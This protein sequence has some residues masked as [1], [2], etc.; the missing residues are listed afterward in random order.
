MW[1]GTHWVYCSSAWFM[2]PLVVPVG[3]L[4]PVRA[5]CFRSCAEIVG[6]VGNLV[7]FCGGFGDLFLLQF[8]LLQIFFRRER[9]HF[10]GD[11]GGNLCLLVLN[12]VSLG[13]VDAGSLLEVQDLTVQILEERDLLFEVPDAV[14][15]ALAIFG[16]LL[17]NFGDRVLGVGRDGRFSSP[18]LEVFVRGCAGHRRRGFR[19]DWQ[20]HLASFGPLGMPLVSTVG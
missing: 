8:D 16:H 1:P 13:L 6:L 4:R 19:R 9:F 5:R 18:S 10:L 14:F 17:L 15:C 7:Q 20:A 12:C 3:D 2:P 11:V